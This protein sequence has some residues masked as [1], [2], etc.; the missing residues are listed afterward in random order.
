[1]NY[2]KSTSQRL[3]TFFNALML[4]FIS[5]ICLLPFVN[6]LALSFSE[7]SAVMAGVV[8][9]WPVQ[10]TIQPYLYVLGRSAFWQAFLVT[11]ERVFIGVTISVLLTIM[12]AYPLSKPVTKFQWRTV[13]A[14]V[15]FFTMLFYGGLIPSYLLVKDLQLMDTIWALVLPGAVNVFNILLLLNFFRQLPLE[16]EDSALIDG[17]GHFR[18]MWQIYVP[19]SLP[20]IATVVLFSIVGHWNSWFDGLIYMNN[21][22]HYP[23]Q[24]YL[25]TIIVQFNFQSMS[26]RELERLMK[27]NVRSVKSAQMVVAALPILLVYPFLQKYFTKGIILGSVKG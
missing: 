18:I 19:I 4:I 17:A 7:N 6:I 20:A 13:Y 16:L 21:P 24:T 3:F 9:L 8:K 25:Q 27:M 11:L 26:P 1:M 15:F 14:W 22:Q 2:N 12:A 23:L 5:L 10:F